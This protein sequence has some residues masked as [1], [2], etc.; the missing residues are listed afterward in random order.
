MSNIVLIRAIYCPYM[1]RVKTRMDLSSPISSIV[2]SAHGVVLSILARTDVPLSGRQAARLT[3]GRVGQR[4][5]SQVLRELTEAGVVTCD[6]HPP[7]KLYRLNREHLAAD[8][9]EILSSLREQLLERLRNE[10]EQWTVGAPA[11]WLFG[12]AA[13]GDGGPDSDIDLLVLRP[14]AT[15]IDNDVWRGQV[16]AIAE[17]VL[18]WTGN[19]CEVVE[20]SEAEFG[21]HVRSAERLVAELKRDAI[22][23]AGETIEM[24]A[25]PEIA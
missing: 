16:D 25:G 1:A 4:R 8:A 13:R 15:D 9:I 17:R 19:S 10:V 14:D 24:R 5:V 3:G 22:H 18:V 6:E 7:A 23:I 12:S 21:A 20:Y 11:V 2:P